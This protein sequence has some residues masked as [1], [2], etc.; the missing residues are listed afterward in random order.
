V[1]PDTGRVYPSVEVGVAAGEKREDLVE[2]AGSL[3]QVRRISEAVKD[4]NRR[5]NKAARKARKKNR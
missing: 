3:A 4:A 2:I 1:N 5:R